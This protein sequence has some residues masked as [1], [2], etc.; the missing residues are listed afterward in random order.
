MYVVKC[1]LYTP[2][3]L[4]VCPLVSSRSLVIKTPYIGWT[5]FFE[6]LH[7]IYIYIYIYIY[8]LKAGQMSP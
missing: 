8:T 5:E 1:A 6:G 3:M 4:Y 2:S 7:I